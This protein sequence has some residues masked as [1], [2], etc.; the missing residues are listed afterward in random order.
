MTDALTTMEQL[1][2]HAAVTYF[3]QI[4]LPYMLEGLR[5]ENN[6]TGLVSILDRY[7]A[8]NLQSFPNGRIPAEGWPSH[9]LA[10]CLIETLRQVDDDGSLRRLFTETVERYY[11]ELLKDLPELTEEPHTHGH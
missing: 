1:D 11:S 10:R 9:F 7:M 6:G 5:R 3:R 2:H 8:L 4:G